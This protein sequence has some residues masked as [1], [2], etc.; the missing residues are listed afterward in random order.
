MLSY[1]LEKI[2][3]ALIRA[4][5][6]IALRNRAAIRGLGNEMVAALDASDSVCVISG[7]FPNAWFFRDFDR[8]DRHIDRRR[9]SG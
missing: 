1:A 8:V 2:H 5:G 9:R 6:E 4:A 3:L 7:D